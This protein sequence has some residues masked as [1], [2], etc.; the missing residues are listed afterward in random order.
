MRF[1]DEYILVFVKSALY[2]GPPL[3]QNTHFLY[4]FHFCKSLKPYFSCIQKYKSLSTYRVMILGQPMVI[5]SSVDSTNNYAMAQVRAGLAKP[6]QAWLA[7]E[8]TSGRGQR[9]KT[10]VSQP[11]EN[12]I[13]SIAMRPHL[14]LQQQFLLSAAVGLGV[15]DFF[16]KLAGDE[17]KIKWPNDIYWRDRKAGGILIEN[18]VIGDGPVAGNWPWS[19]IG[20]GLNINQ[21]SFP[22]NVLNAVSLLQ[23]TGKQWD[24]IT[25]TKDLCVCLQ[26]RIEQLNDSTTLLTNYNE[27]LYKRGETVRLKKDTRIFDATIIAVNSLGQ[28][29]TTT[30]MEEVFGFGEVEWLHSGTM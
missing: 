21:S 11:G 28:L 3:L 29:V 22:D 14:S 8:Q 4:H 16:S 23:I 27:V 24:L 6:G 5:L 1:N 9:Q 15:H 7:L 13:I 26:K 19:V 10:W 20:I 30:G 2:Q 25:L 17:T 12:I 18:L